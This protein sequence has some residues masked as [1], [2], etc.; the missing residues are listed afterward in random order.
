MT[1][2]PLTE[3]A[4]IRHSKEEDDKAGLKRSFKEQ[5]ADYI[6]KVQKAID[7]EFKGKEIPDNVIEI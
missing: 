3:A 2:D 5:M 4:I 7:L 6:E 1:N